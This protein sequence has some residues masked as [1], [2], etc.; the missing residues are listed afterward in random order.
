MNK[1]ACATVER[2]L[3]AEPSVMPVDCGLLHK[4]EDRNM[5]ATMED[6]LCQ[7]VTIDVIPDFDLLD[8]IDC[9]T[10]KWTQSCEWFTDTDTS[11][12][13]KCVPSSL[14]PSFHLCSSHLCKCFGLA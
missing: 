11:K 14:N 9:Q 7:E 1:T 8:E 4:A 3:L 6:I 2:D 10:S 5:A 13:S 12:P